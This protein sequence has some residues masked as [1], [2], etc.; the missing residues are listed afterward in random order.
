[1]WFRNGAEEFQTEKRNA[2]AEI[3]D[4]KAEFEGLVQRAISAG[5]AGHDSLIT[6]VRGQFAD[7]EGKIGP[8]ETQEELDTL[9]SRAGALESLGAYMW[10]KQE[11][12]LEGEADLNTMREW[13]VPDVVITRYQET[14]AAKLGDA[15][16]L[17]ARGAL[18]IIF[19]EYDAWSEYVDDYNL[20]MRRSAAWLTTAVMGLTLLAAFLL[21]RGGVVW[22]LFTAGVAGACV[23]VLSKMP[24]LGTWGEF[25]AYGRGVLRRVAV[26]AAASVIGSGLLVSGLLGV[27]LGD[28]TIREIITHCTYPTSEKAGD[29]EIGIGGDAESKP[30]AWGK[31]KEFVGGLLTELTTPGRQGCGT[32]HL[33]ILMAIAML[34][35]FSERAMASFEETLFGRRG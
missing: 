34:L 6:Y 26:G 22:G 19:Q 16:V 25:A 8:A 5:E 4:K 35:G 21:W 24:S 7:V 10:P 9:V 3:E 18:Y 33:L 30:G 28:Q 1:M 32:S 20:S 12:R 2:R 15:N 23:S 11:I 29:R 27:S 17:T 31:V 13:G 14:L